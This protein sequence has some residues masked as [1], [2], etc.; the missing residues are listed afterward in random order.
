[1]T[2]EHFILF[3]TLGLTMLLGAVLQRTGFCT[4]G[5]IA[6]IFLISRLDRIRQW[7]LAIGI[8][9]ISVSIFS[10]LGIID[11]TKSIYANAKVMYLSVL[12]G[13][14]L[15]GCGMVLA[16]GCGAKTLIRIGGGNL[17]SLVVFIVMSLVAYMTLRGFLGVIRVDFLD[18][19]FFTLS[20]P[21][22]LP[23]VLSSTFEVS[24]P[25]M[26]LSLGLL[27]GGGLILFA[28]LSKSF[29]T[30]NNLLAGL[31]VGFSISL[32]WLISGYLGYI[33]EDPNTL[34]EA[35]LL[36][37]SGKM[38]S[39]SFV[40]PYAY[41]IDWLMFYSDASRVLTIGI[42]AVLGLTLGSALYAIQARTFRWESFSS[43]EDTANHLVGASFMGF[44]GIAALGCTFGQGLSGI[45]TLAISSFLAIIGFFVGAYLAL[46][47]LQARL[48]LKPCS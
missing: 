29:W 47:Y 24:R 22:D 4:M 13:S 12:L 16:S 17:K 2:P 43:V 46:H 39:L 40:G 10:G 1:M 38:E 7:A 28:L 23:S 3:A 25:V 45:S 20:G 37:N 8:S 11:S 27:I 5:A 30:F 26:H 9:I 33:Q 15:F 18:S 31:T 36:T 34:Q 19:V 32:M 14:I 6:D 44:G 48:A 41:A 42:V 35:F 21:Q